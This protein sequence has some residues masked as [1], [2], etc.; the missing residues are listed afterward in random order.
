MYLSFTALN[1]ED[2]QHLTH[3]VQTQKLPGLKKLNLAGIMLSEMETEVEHLIETCV[4]HHQRELVLSLW[5][6]GLSGAFREKWNQRCAG[7]KI[8]L[9]F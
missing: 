4:N 9:E 1:K 7:T 8:Q 5:Y 2:L 6:N 3:L